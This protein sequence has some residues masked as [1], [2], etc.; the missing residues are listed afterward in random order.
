M[1][2]AINAIPPIQ[3]PTIMVSTSIAPSTSSSS[4]GPYH[5]NTLLSVGVATILELNNK[6]AVLAFQPPVDPGTNKQTTCPKRTTVPWPRGLLGK[7][8]S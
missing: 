8:T 2:Q 6:K 3:P 4:N 7:S 5:E 1:A